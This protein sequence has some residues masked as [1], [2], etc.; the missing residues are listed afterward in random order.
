MN[1]SKK[2]IITS[3]FIAMGVVL[4]LCF[5]MIPSGGNIFLPMHLPVILG[6]MVV[7]PFYGI[8]IG[9][10]TPTI[11]HL[12]TSMPPAAVYPGMMLEL[13]SYA[14]FSGLFVKVIKTKNNILNAYLALIPSMLIGRI[15]SGLTNAFIFQAGKYNFHTWITLSF[16]TSLP[17]IIIQLAIIPAL[18]V[19]INNVVLSK[20][21]ISNIEIDSKK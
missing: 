12:L 21:K 4:P 19:F 15:V 8:L 6:G 10:L 3:L 16:V 20:K 14:F 5:H 9:I 1:Q 13:I 17:G 11:S 2:I 18:Y 7:G